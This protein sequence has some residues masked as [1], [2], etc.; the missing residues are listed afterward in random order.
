[1]VRARICGIGILPMKGQSGS[2]HRLEADATQ[3]ITAN[4][5]SGKT[6]ATRFENCYSN[7]G[8]DA[9]SFPVSVRR[10]SVVRE[11][12]VHRPLAVL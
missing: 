6:D 12:I 8:C 7:D 11:A 1:M 10:Q 9:V 4:G 2:D 3:A 5:T